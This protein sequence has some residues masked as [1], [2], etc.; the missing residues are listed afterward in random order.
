MPN[1]SGKRGRNDQF[2]RIHASFSF[3]SGDHALRR[4]DFSR[5]YAQVLRF[6]RGISS[7]CAFLPRI[8]ASFA[9]WEGYFILLCISPAHT[10]KFQLNKF[11]L[12]ETWAGSAELDRY[13]V[14]FRFISVAKH[15]FPA[16]SSNLYVFFSTTSLLRT[17]YGVEGRE[18]PPP[19]TLPR[20][21]A[22][23]S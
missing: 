17:V 4:G 16:E 23:F 14:R 21:R 11:L 20:I 13:L 12:T 2:P 8:R 3:P 9:F 18:S 1:T 15:T 5:A 10:R 6:G 19:K 7:C 22:S